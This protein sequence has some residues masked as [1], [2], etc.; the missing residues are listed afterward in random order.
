MPARAAGTLACASLHVRSCKS[1]LAIPLLDEQQPIWIVNV[2]LQP[3]TMASGLIPHDRADNRG[4]LAAGQV[5]FIGNNR[6]SD[7]NSN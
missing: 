5:D 3:D 4:E 2:L 7:E 1:L 6:A